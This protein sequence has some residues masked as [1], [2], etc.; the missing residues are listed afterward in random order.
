MIQNL[1]IKLIGLQA[2]YKKSLMNH[3]KELENIRLN[4][5]LTNN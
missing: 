1:G 5:N 2:S 3:K 4:S